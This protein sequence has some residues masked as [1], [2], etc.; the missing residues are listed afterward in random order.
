LIEAT[1]AA[2]RGMKRGDE[3]RA[4]IS[5]A[6]AGKKRGPRS[7][8]TI[9]KVAACHRGRKRSAETRERISVAMAG[10]K[11]PAISAAM[12]GRKRPDISAALS[13]RVIGPM[14]EERKA[15]LSAARTGLRLSD[16]AKAERRAKMAAKREAAQPMGAL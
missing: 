1:A 8:E 11:R 4:K 13:G 7:Q 5:A 15:K 14:S 12:A 16:E 3:T 9:E 10:K 6:L 2:H